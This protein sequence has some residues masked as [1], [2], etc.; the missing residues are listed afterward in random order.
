MHVG[1]YIPSRSRPDNVGTLRGL[2]QSIRSK[3]FVM[4]TK[5]QKKEYVAANPGVHI[6][7]APASAVD[8]GTK[9]EAIIK[10]ARR[11][12][13]TH[14]IMFDDDLRFFV[15]R[16]DDT[17]KFAPATGPDVARM[18]RLIERKLKEGY[19]HVGVTAKHGSN[20][21]PVGGMEV[22]RM[23]RV[24]AYDLSVLKEEKVRYD[25][26]KLMTDF[27]VTLQL[28]RKGYPNFVVTDFAQD[29]AGSNTEGGC[30]EYRTK[31]M[32]A[33]AAHQLAEFHHPF[34]KVVEKETKGSW[35]GGK[36]TDVVIY[37][38]KAFAG[39]RE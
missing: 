5:G 27:D 37:W 24:L 12:G 3:V 39:R 14:I 16:T 13:F 30:S 25:R 35:G 28:L 17:T 18:I 38:K 7:E 21:T 34:V 10:H 4:V 32:L 19:A 22:T 33:E 23:M 6:V 29:H 20:R 1:Y 11:K 26:L 8:A 2:P 36:R 31:E 9:R 15:R